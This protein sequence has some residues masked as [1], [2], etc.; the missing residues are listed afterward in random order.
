MRTIGDQ[1]EMFNNIS[2]ALRPLLIEVPRDLQE[3]LPYFGTILCKYKT[4]Y[5]SDAFCIFIL[6]KQRNAF[7]RLFQSLLWG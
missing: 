1:W 2:R 4:A 3:M 5:N 7:Y 6:R